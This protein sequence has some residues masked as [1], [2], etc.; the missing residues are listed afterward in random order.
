MIFRTFW[1]KVFPQGTKLV[2]SGR[3]FVSQDDKIQPEGELYLVDTSNTSIISFVNGMMTRDG[4]VHVD[5]IVKIIG[6]S[7]LDTIKEKLSNRNKKKK[8][9]TNERFPLTL[10]DVKN[11]IS[12]VASF[13]L[14]NPCFNSQSKTYLT[15]PKPHIHIES[16]VL[17][18][19]FGWKLVENLY[20]LY[21]MKNEDKLKKTDLKK[22]R[23][24]GE[25]K[26]DACNLAGGPRGTECT[27]M[28]FEG[29]SAKA[30]GET[31][32]NYIPKGYDFI[33]L[34]PLRGKIINTINATADKLYNNVELMELKK[35]IGLSEGMD[36]SDPENFKTLRYGRIVIMTDQD[37]DGTHIKALICLYLYKRF[38]S[39]FFIPDGFVFEVILPLI[40]I[41]K[42]SDSY[43]FSS[44]IKYE[45]FMV[46]HPECKGWESKHYKG[47]GTSTK[48]NIVED[49]QNPKYISMI[50]DDNAP[51]AFT[52]AFD[53]HFAEDRKKWV[54][55]FKP[56][57]FSDEIKI[58]RL[59]EFLTYELIQY[60]LD[61]IRRSIPG[62]MDCLKVSQRKIL[63]TALNKWKIY[64]DSH[65]KLKEMKVAKFAADSGAFTE[66]H[67]GEKSLSEAIV[68]MGQT[69]VGANNLPYFTEGGNFG[70]R[71]MAN[72]HSHERY[73]FTKPEW[74]LKFVYRKEDMPLMKLIYD[75]GNACEPETLYPIIPMIV[76]NI[77][78]IGT[79]YSTFI[80]NHNPLD[81]IRWY[82]L[83]LTG[84]SLSEIP[85]V[86]PYYKNF[87]GTIELID[88][89]S[90]KKIKVDHTTE[91]KPVETPFKDKDEVL[92]E[93]LHPEEDMDYIE[94]EDE[95]EDNEILNENKKITPP[96]YS[97]VTKGV[98]SSISSIAVKITELPIGRWIESYKNWL[99][100]LA[101][102]RSIKGY[103][104]GGND[105]TPEF[106]IQGFQKPNLHSLKLVKT[107]GLTNMVFLNENNI[108]IKYNTVAEILEVF[109]H[110]RL[111]IYSLR[112]TNMLQE[113]NKQIAVL[114]DKCR[115]IMLVKDKTIKIRNRLT[116]D[117][118]KDMDIHAL[119]HDLLKNAK[120]T[121]ITQDHIDKMNKKMELL[122]RE[123]HE[124]EKTSREK[125]WY[126]DLVEFEKE[127]VKRE[128]KS[129]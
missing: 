88:R 107:Y 91:W 102:D 19:V 116:N 94:N 55:K 15:E 45:E 98:F 51:N 26:E 66:Y 65:E 33:G 123:Y 50:L 115:F 21:E 14:L 99:E 25:T 61:N 9:V 82:K 69:Y 126:D 64:T 72:N 7:I 81:I 108:P 113:M 38:P 22:K 122:R 5:G 96:K 2:K 93:E 125:L 47:L 59:S 34:L 79:A 121:A 124:L 13:N 60:S 105:I 114:S 97:M 28:I 11:N 128:K 3:T 10:S 53:K 23:F 12:I 78:G 63:W 44:M 46:D 29:I 70:N 16:E 6:K 92:N 127:Y 24:I 40:R 71:T 56:V 90:H 100:Q 74:W 87:K 73:I 32:R 120:L 18:P 17:K 37:S 36:Y 42:N 89:V 35:I 68:G 86:F 75:E 119:P 62:F 83:R 4:G 43:S 95:F 80:P 117:I 129:M 54:E 57:G 1:V 103:T 118:Y 85:T 49:F 84:T 30:Y 27:L 76:N 20:R 101:F 31:A 39:L 67:H 109:Y 52:L 77:I 106:T 104:R 111:E 41:W 110:K 48:D 112:K 8:S 58:K